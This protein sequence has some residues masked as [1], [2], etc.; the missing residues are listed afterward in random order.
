MA[1][2]TG[3]VKELAAI[4]NVSRKSYYQWIKREVT[5]HELEDQDENG[6]S[7]GTYSWLPNTDDPVSMAI[8]P[9]VTYDAL[10]T[11]VTTVEKSNPSN[12]KIVA[13]YTLSGMQV[14]SMEPG[15]IYIVKRADG[16]ASKVK[17]VK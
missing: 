4:A 8:A 3:T 12:S 10:S 17:I 6:R 16:T 1:E 7:L 15:H 5:K 14:D 9:V 2:K 13:I 11:A